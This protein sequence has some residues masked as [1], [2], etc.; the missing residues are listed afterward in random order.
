MTDRRLNTWLETSPV[1]PEAGLIGV[2]NAWPEIDLPGIDPDRIRAIQPMAGPYETLVERGL[3]TAKTIDR[4]YDAV[5]LRAPREK[6]RALSYLKE[7]VRRS[8]DGAPII[9]DGQKTDGIESLLK[10][11]RRRFEVQDVYSKDHGKVFWFKKFALDQDSLADLDL[12]EPT[13]TL[14]PMGFYTAP[15]VF[16][17]DGPDAASVALAAALPPLKGH[18]IDLGA[19]W[20]YLSHEILKKNAPD[21]LDLVEAD[22]LALT[23]AQKNINSDVAIFHWADARSFRPETPADHVVTN[24]PFH[25]GRAADPALGQAFI[26]SAAAMLK[27]SGTL[28]L[29]ANR[30]LPYE[31]TLEA[32]FRDVQTLGLTP[33]FKL[34][35]A[36]RPVSPRKG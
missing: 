17:A 3:N 18:V 19:G 28:W 10:L 9:I 5:I 36:S 30:H 11:C 8:P 24:P 12:P 13:P 22:W 35:S 6:D 4:S 27:P 15:G 14:K 1:L 2:F 31:K 21:Q 26:R 33:Q 25:T 34:Y 23:C 32:S 16:S 20:G 7:A 29:V